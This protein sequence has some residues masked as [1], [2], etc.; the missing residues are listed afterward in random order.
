MIRAVRYRCS[1]RGIPPVVNMRPCLRYSGRVT[2]QGALVIAGRGKWQHRATVTNREDRDLA[3]FETL[4]ER[5]CPF[6]RR[7]RQR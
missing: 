5:K 7:V 6:R 4:L 3:P 2:V 1:R